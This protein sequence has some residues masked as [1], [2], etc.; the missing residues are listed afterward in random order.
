MDNSQSPVAHSLPLDAVTTDLVA[1]VVREQGRITLALHGQSMTPT[2]PP[3]ARVAVERWD[4]AAL[5]PGHV[6]AFARDG[7]IIAHRV[8]R[9]QSGPA[10]L[11]FITKGDRGYA[12]DATVIPATHVIGRV[13]E[14]QDPATG[15]HRPLDEPAQAR[16]WVWWGRGLMALGHWKRWLPRRLGR[17]G[18][19]LLDRVFE[20]TNG[21]MD[22]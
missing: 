20:W 14:A 21:R 10:G 5:R 16:F 9:V 6:I 13:T 1:Q 22:E 3:G 2:L 7:H 8:M 17:A 15:A 19:R 11:L 12:A 18:R 4:P